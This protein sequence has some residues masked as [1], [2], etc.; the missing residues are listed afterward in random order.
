MR[1]TRRSLLAG[2]AA[3]LVWGP[4][5]LAA[6][7]QVPGA[8]LR[9]WSTGNARLAPPA[10]AARWVLYAGDQTIGVIRPDR[11]DGTDPLWA[12]PHGLAGA[13][14]FRPRAADGRL[15][16][17]GPQGIG[18][19]RLADGEYLWGYRPRAQLGVPLVA[20]QR[21]YLGDGHEVIALDNRT[22]DPVWRFAGL[23]DTLIS[24]APAMA[25]ETLFVGSGD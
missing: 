18:C 4:P 16:C 1:L 24:Y 21:T 15:V 17:G 2:L 10:R 9:R 7:T 12:R 20:A 6:Q 11:P 5:R 19:W 25:G 13:A 23:A 14:Q 8:V 22:G 3:G